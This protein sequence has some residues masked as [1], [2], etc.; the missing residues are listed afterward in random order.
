MLQVVQKG[1]EEITGQVVIISYDLVSKCIDRLRER[2]FG[3]IVLD[4]PK[5]APAAAHLDRAAR[6][7][8]E[9]NR[10]ALSL[11]SSGGALF[12]FSCSG[13]V[14]ADLFQKIIAAAVI[15][16]G[17]DC[18]L[19]RRL[20]AGTDHPIAMTHPEGEYLKGLL[21]RRD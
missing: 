2:K 6:A 1:K 10:K 7:Y 11:L 19:V 3:M 16:S 20:G 5:F 21:L 9:I 4:P 15:D 8:K 14:N 17:V 12:T 13:A 18:S